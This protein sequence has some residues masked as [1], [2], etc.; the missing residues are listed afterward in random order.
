MRMKRQRLIKQ[1]TLK[2]ILALGF[3]LFVTSLPGSIP[4][5]EAIPAFARKYQVNCHVCHTRQPRLNP[6]GERF[7]ENGYQMP[8]TEDGGI[9]AKLKYGD[10][11][12]DQVSNYLG[13]LFATSGVEHT[14][15]KREIE[16][17]GDQTEL[18]TPAILRMF[19]VGT[20]T[21]NVGFF[22]DM[23]TIFGES[24][25]F[26][27][28]RAFITLNN[29]GGMNWGHLR[30]GRFDPSAFFSMAQ[31]R[32]QFV[33]VGPKLASPFGEF[34]TPTVNRWAL[35]QSA[36]ASKFYGLFDRSGTAIQPWEP[37]LFNSAE[38][39]GI[40]IHGRPFGDWFL[41]QVGILNGGNERAGDSNNSKD[42]YVMT[43]FDYAQSHDFS[44]N[45][46]G[47]AFIGNHNAKVSTNADVSR[48][49]Y[50]VGARLRYKW[51]DVYG[52]YTIDRV[53]DLPSGME[54]TFDSTAT[55]VTVEAH[56]LVTDRLLLGTRYDHMDAGGLLA[57]RKSATFV[58]LQAKYYLRSNMT[59]T[60]RDDFNVRDAE[61]GTSA[62]RN[63]RNRFSVDLAIVF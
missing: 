61:G 10:L 50:G 38:E 4:D 8:G 37:T 32:P 53:T 39:V 42:W 60:I 11:T 7:L 36:E 23:T 25:D 19:T 49:R 41:Y 51:L 2:S 29:L 30:V 15:F 16:G 28:G 22:V 40:D 58:G 57:T 59:F 47:F 52:A 43:R 14:E 31:A 13:V 55:G 62:A 27:L 3:V 9:V 44:A 35:T 12:L 21:N 1:P 34:S 54:A 6:F 5:A 18:G 46:S 20:V 33:P 17:S 56:A 63:L 45:I 48:S 26:E 24:S